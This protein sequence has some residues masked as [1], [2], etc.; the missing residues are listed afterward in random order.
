MRP[1][2][3]NHHGVKCLACENLELIEPQIEVYHLNPIGEAER[4]TIIEVIPLCGN[5]HR[6][7]QAIDCDVYGLLVRFLQRV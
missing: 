1:Y 4:R 5:C 6:C 7:A 2:V 3:L